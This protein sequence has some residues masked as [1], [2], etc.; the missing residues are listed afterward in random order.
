V[1]LIAYDRVFVTVATVNVRDKVQLE[2][3]KYGVFQGR[4]YLKLCIIS[5]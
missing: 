1:F 4:G 2:S 5:L 3:G